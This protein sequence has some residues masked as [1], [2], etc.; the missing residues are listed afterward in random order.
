[1]NRFNISLAST[2]SVQLLYTDNIDYDKRSINVRKTMME[3][4]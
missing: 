1:M 2:E 4:Y 3:I